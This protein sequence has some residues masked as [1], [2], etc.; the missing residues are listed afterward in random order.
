MGILRVAL[1]DL[2][3]HLHTPLFAVNSVARGADERR[4]AAALLFGLFDMD[5]RYHEGRIDG[6]RS[7]GM[8]HREYFDR[9]PVRPR[10]PAD[11]RDRCFAVR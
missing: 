4:G 10:P 7:R 9:G 3:R 11:L 2:C 6:E 1:E 5:R 8:N